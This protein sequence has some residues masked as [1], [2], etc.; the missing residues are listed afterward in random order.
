MGKYSRQ[1][2]AQ[3]ERYFSGADHTDALDELYMLGGTSGGARSK[4]MTEY[5][6]KEWI[7]K[8]P[9]HTDANDAGGILERFGLT[10]KR[11]RIKAE[12][13]TRTEDIY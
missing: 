7:I 1:P 9:A 13:C 11:P 6:Q 4:I 10:V 12:M 8:F 5:D 3:K 2:D